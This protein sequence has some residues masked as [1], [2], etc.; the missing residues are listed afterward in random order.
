MIEVIAR[1]FG[2]VLPIPEKAPKVALS[3]G[4]S[5]IIIQANLPRLAEGEV[6][7]DATVANAPISFRLWTVR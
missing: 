1:K 2:L 5:L 7:S 3:S 4:D 6:H